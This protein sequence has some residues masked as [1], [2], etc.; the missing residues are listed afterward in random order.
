MSSSSFTC[1]KSS[2]LASVARA[3]RAY[4]KISSVKVITQAA[5]QA[6]EHFK[7]AMQKTITGESTLLHYH[8][9]SDALSVYAVPNNVH[10]GLPE[11]HELH[12]TAQEMEEVYPVTDVVT[13]LTRQQGDTEA[14]FYDA[15]AEVM[16]R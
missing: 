9:V 3:A 4:R 10:V 15:L 5:C 12:G 2:D 14:A 16:S 7:T 8:N 11:S 13:D 1:V 6:G